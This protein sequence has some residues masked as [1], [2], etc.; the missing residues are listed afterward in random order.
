MDINGNDLKPSQA[1]VFLYHKDQYIQ[2]NTGYVS[3]PYMILLQGGQDNVITFESVK[4]ILLITELKVCSLEDYKMP[5]YE[6]YIS[7]YQAELDKQMT[8]KEIGAYKYESEGSGRTSSTPTLYPTT[9]RTSATNYPTDPVK[10][11]YNAIGGAKWTTAGDS[12]T[13]TVNAEEAGLYQL[14]FRAKQD[15]ARGMFATRKLY[16]DGVQPF[17]EAANLRFYYNSEYNLV[18]LGTGAGKIGQLHV[19]E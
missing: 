10:T 14:A 12:I 6:E 4:E 2:D 16:V 11:K 18:S 7:K 13:W 9:D 19:W 3:K 1:E 8:I 17:E 15:L 5:T